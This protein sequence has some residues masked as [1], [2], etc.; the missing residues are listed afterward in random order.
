MYAWLGVKGAKALEGRK[1][2][3]L[4]QIWPPGRLMEGLF[5]LSA[6]LFFMGRFD[7]HSQGVK[8]CGWPQA[9]RKGAA[10]CQSLLSFQRRLCLCLVDI[11]A[12]PYGPLSPPR[13][14]P[15]FISYPG[16]PRPLPFCLPPFFPAEAAATVGNAGHSHSPGH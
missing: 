6:S 12:S 7:F 15:F 14:A 3:L 2:V 9:L 5:S 16:P 10:L 1:G 4:E 13:V 8:V 11:A